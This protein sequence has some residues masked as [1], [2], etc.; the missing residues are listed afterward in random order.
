MLWG[1][2]RE[3]SSCPA[4]NWLNGEDGNQKLLAAREFRERLSLIMRPTQESKSYNLYV[5]EGKMEF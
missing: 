2:I 3:K 4:R 5:R 1:L